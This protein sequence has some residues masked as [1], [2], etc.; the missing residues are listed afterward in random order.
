MLPA[1]TRQILP[2]RVE[3]NEIREPHRLMVRLAMHGR[4]LVASRHSAIR[5]AR[6][7]CRTIFVSLEE[8]FPVRSPN[9]RRRLKLISAGCL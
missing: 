8:A 9:F 5:E 2:G 6:R 4:G 7:A 3:D 1:S